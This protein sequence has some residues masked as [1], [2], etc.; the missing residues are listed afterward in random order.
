MT[1]ITTAPPGRSDARARAQHG[2]DPLAVGRERG[3]A[4][5]GGRRAEL[6]LAQV[7]EVEKLVGGAV[8]L[9][10]VDQPGIRR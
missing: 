2:R 8:L 7:V 1:T 10:V 5:P 9:V 4:R 3:A 6:E